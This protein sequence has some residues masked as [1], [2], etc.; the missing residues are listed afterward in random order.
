MTDSAPRSAP[1]SGGADPRPDQVRAELERIERRWATLPLASA[2]A[3]M[4]SLRRALDSLTSAAGQ[5]PV[6][7][8]GPGVALHQLKVLVWEACREGRADGIPELLTVLRRAL[9]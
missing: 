6:T 9:P 3:G 4:P 1:P 5:P 2:E 7:D 8:L